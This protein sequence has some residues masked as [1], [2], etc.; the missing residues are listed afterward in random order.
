MKKGKFEYY[1][2]FENGKEISGSAKDSFSTLDE[3]EKID[4]HEESEAVRINIRR[5]Y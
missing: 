3:I 1:I 5:I 4:A 2:R